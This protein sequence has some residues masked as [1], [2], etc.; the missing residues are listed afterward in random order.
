MAIMVA[1]P[2]T[3]ITDQHATALTADVLNQPVVIKIVI[4]LIVGRRA[5]TSYASDIPFQELLVHA[6][7]ESI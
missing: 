3:T 5:Q 2:V 4:V 1:S 6:R 7:A